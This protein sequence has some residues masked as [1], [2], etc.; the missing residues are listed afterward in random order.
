M[1]SADPELGDPPAATTL[2][3]ACSDPTDAL[4]EAVKVTVAE[5][6]GNIPHRRHAQAEALR[7]TVCGDSHC[8]G[9]S[10]SAL[11]DDRQ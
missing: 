5:S 1:V 2:S 9:E 4:G 7:K 10:A 6:P 3:R 11:N 8:S